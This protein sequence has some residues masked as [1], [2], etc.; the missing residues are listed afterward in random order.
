MTPTPA[1]RFDPKIALIALLL[2]LLI[3]QGGFASAG[4]GRDGGGGDA[5]RGLIAVTGQ[6]G[7]GAAALYVIDTKSRHM[8]VY[9]L[10]NGRELEFVSARNMTY[11]FYLESVNDRSRDWLKPESLRRSWQRFNQNP[12]DEAKETMPAPEKGVEGTSPEPGKKPD[13][14]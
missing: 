1:R 11:D 4:S 7:S 12:R 3:W 6:Y 10:E 2:G 13:D 8:A 14:R 5:D 9:R